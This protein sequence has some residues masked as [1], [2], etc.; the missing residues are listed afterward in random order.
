MS[1]FKC[2]VHGQRA[3]EFRRVFGTATVDV[4]TPVPFLANLPGRPR[5][6]VY[7]LDLKSLTDEQRAAL[8]ARSAEHFNLTVEDTRA[9]IENVGMPILAEGCTITIHNPQRWV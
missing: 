7:L 5:S 6:L 4:T 9:E 3:E 1:D 2:T 8:V